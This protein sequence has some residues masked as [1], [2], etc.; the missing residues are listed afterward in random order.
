MV[1]IF[2]SFVLSHTLFGQYLPFFLHMACTIFPLLRSIKAIGE[3][4]STNELSSSL[5]FWV[6]YV[7]SSYFD[8]LIGQPLPIY[9]DLKAGFFLYIFNN[10]LKVLS[11]M[12]ANFEP[13]FAKI[14]RSRAQMI[15]KQTCPMSTAAQSTDEA[16]DKEE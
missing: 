4:E 6:L 12:R 7:F 2:I 5:F 10:D 9:Y 13:L 11:K 3:K 16:C 14:S 8:S 15:G 1:T